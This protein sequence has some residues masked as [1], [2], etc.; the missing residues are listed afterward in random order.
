VKYGMSPLQ[1]LRSATSQAAALMRMEDQVGSVQPGRF[2]DLIAV[3]G[4]PLS[5]ISV[6][7]EIQFVMKGGEVFGS[8]H[9]GNHE[10]F[11]P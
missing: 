3:Q 10:T 2:A 7:Q 5:D 6:T 8:P 11:S 9:K 1:A 4:D